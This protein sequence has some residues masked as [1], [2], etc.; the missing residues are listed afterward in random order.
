MARLRG[1]LIW[2]SAATQQRCSSLPLRW[3]R[4][5]LWPAA[6]WAHLDRPAAHARRAPGTQQWTVG[7]RPVACEA[8]V[9]DPRRV[10][11]TRMYCNLRS[12]S[13]GTALKHAAQQQ[14][15][16]ITRFSFV[17]QPNT[18]DTGYNAARALR[19]F[20]GRDFPHPT[21]RGRGARA[22]GIPTP[23]WHTCAVRCYARSAAKSARPGAAGQ[24]RSVPAEAGS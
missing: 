18:L 4:T 1:P 24:A 12:H 23:C 22:Y 5:G 9:K 6:R 13:I 15:I 11:K 14:H 20:G 8:G 16:G 10:R 3:C 19:W 21:A 7:L 2:Q 17:P